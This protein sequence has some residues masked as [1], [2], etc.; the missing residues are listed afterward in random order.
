MALGSRGVR[1]TFVGLAGLTPT[2]LAVG[3]TD[4]SPGSFG[5]L[6]GRVAVLRAVGLADLAPLKPE[7][8]DLEGER[9]R[10]DFEGIVV[11]R[12]QGKH[13]GAV[14]ERKNGKGLDGAISR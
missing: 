13:R 11:L 4:F 2:V 9:P 8:R 5:G 7:E 1:A 12:R 6:G 3:R 14:G 10:L